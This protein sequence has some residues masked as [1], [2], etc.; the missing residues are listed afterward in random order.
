MEIAE[1][2]VYWDIQDANNQGWAYVALG[3]RGL[4]SSG[5]VDAESLDEAIDQAIS[6]LGVDFTHDDFAR[7]HE[8]GGYAIWCEL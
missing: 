2:T 4:I 7:H 6:E 8:E 3:D 1:I 5:G